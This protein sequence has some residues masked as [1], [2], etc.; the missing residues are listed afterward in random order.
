MK[1][2]PNVELSRPHSPPLGNERCPTDN[3]ESASSL[4][5]KI[6]SRRPPGMSS[7]G[8]AIHARAPKPPLQFVRK[9]E[10]GRVM[11]DVGYDS[12]GLNE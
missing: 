1:A 11:A 8:N 10:R 6:G 2:L 5:G 4:N 3:I 7:V 9:Q 12:E